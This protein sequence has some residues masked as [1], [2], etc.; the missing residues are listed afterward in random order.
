M[1]EYIDSHVHLT[2]RKFARDL[3]QVL[4]RA[5]E[6]GV[7]HMVDI[8]YSLGSSYK[9]VELAKKHPN[10]HAV[11]GIHPHDAKRCSEEAIE[12]L[13][14]LAKEPEVVAVG[15]MGLDYFRDLSP[16]D[17]QQQA[18][19]DQLALAKRVGKPVVIHDRDAHGPVMDILKQEKVDEVGGVLHC[20]SGSW[21]MAR[22]VMK[23][24]MY[25]SIA[26]PVSFHNARRLK[27]IA[28]LVPLDFLMIETDCPYLTPE[29]YRGQR[30][31]PAYVVRVA[32]TIAEVKGLPLE[33][34]AAATTANAKKLFGIA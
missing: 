7:V 21:E 5:E 11:V 6:A 3:P 27:D 20:F 12:E 16:R 25:I 13:E 26:G 19:R 18:F 30:N 10:I 34:V 24:G 23:L 14:V 8:A 1:I 9:V 32:E 33:E 31:E 29:P 2:D 4:K 22:E 15:E 28:R 17:K